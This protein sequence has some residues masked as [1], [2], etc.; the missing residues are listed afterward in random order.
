MRCLYG[1]AT[2][3]VLA[4]LSACNPP[5]DG[6]DAQPSG[7]PQNKVVEKKPSSD[8]A[9]FDEI[10]VSELE[11]IK[12]PTVSGIE[13]AAA[14]RINAALASIRESAVKSATEC[15]ATAGSTP[16]SYE[17]EAEPGYNADNVLSLRI[18]G[19]AFCGGANGSTLVDARTFDLTT[20]D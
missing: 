11:G 9:T 13:T 14:D 17:F 18:T 1:L 4:G 5:A 20:G 7:M 19:H 6:S 2:I 15:K 12:I 10:Q 16:F 8:A 3:A